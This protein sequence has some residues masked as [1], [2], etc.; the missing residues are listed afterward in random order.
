MPS[1][2]APKNPK[3]AHIVHVD[4]LSSIVKEGCLW[5]DAEVA[6]RSLSGTTI[7]IGEIKRR[8][9]SHTLMSHPTL[10]VG[11]CVP[12]YFWPRS[13]M[14][15]VIHRKNHESLT[16][17]GGQEQIVH[18]VADLRQTVRWADGAGLRWA[19]TLSNAGAA[20]FE[21]RAT[22]DE[23]GDIDWKAVKARDWRDPLIKER[24]QAEFLVEGRFAWQLVSRIGVFNDST[25]RQV[26]DAL[27]GSKHQP[28]VEVRPEWYYY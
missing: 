26:T 12:F 5:C 17:R 25:R 27:A 16:F 3:I 19:F 13:V 28:V 11:Q 2:V 10:K 6:E 15:Y 20:F 4:R 9:M 7:G 21:D 8:R 1:T 23:L 22:L 14:L 24:K 18:L